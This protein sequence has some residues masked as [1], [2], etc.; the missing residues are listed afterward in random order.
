LAIGK[1]VFMLILPV[2]DLMAGQVVRGIGGRRK[3]YRPIVSNLAATSA[4]CDVAAALRQRFSLTHFYVADLDALAGAPPDIAT[5]KSL[6][7]RGFRL[8]VDAGLRDS[9]DAAPL[10]DAGVE[11]LVFGLETSHGPQQLRRACKRYGQRV[12]FSLDLKN[13]EPLGDRQC[14][15]N[16][17]AWSIVEQAVSAGIHRMIVLDLARV[18]GGGGVGTESLCARIVEAFPRV[19][20]IA[21]GG[22]RGVEDLRRLRA[23]GVSGVLLASALHDGSI[24]PDQLTEFTGS[25]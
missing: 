7:E 3:E 12:V 8:C 6:Q 2:L 1:V 14:W 17:D 15:Q 16:G 23:C 19:R 9:D 24:T 10:L 5:Y 22:V 13:G 20:L 25:A 11:E 18:G 21:G 4:P